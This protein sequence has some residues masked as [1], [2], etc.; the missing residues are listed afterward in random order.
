MQFAFESSCG[1]KTDL[2]DELFRGIWMV[3]NNRLRGN[4]PEAMTFTCQNG[5]QRELVGF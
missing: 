3:N 5:S 2:V 4:L 1:F